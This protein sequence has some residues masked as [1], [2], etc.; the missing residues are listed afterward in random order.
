[1]LANE[2]KLRILQVFRAHVGGLFRGVM[3]LAA[4]LAS[5]GQEVGLIVD[6]LGGGENAES[7]LAA[8]AQMAPHAR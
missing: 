1:M 7:Q 3:D 6:S 5:R 2:P 8:R 4:E